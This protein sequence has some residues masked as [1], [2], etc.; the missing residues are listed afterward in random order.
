MSQELM[1]IHMLLHEPI[2]KREEAGVPGGNPRSQI[3][4]D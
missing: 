4:I 2:L 3:E 1:T